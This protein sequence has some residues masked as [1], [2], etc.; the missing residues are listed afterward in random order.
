MNAFTNNNVLVGHDVVLFAIQ[1]YGVDGAEAAGLTMNAL[2]Y[3]KDIAIE[4]MNDWAEVTP[5]SETL[6]ER[7]WLDLDWRARLNYQVRNG[8]SH[9]Y[10]N[11]V[12]GV[13][14]VLLAFTEEFSGNEVLLLGGIE[15]GTYERNREAGSD[16]LEVI[17]VGRT[18]ALAGYSFGYL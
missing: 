13:Q 7:R 18:A 16:A 9:V 11:F 5:S 4:L 8:G 2:G 14:K 17:N 1:N 10:Y 15:R 6:K 12:Q 3:W